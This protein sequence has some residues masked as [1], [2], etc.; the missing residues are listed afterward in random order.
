[1][2]ELFNNIKD[3]YLI[4]DYVIATSNFEHMYPE[5]ANVRPKALLKTIASYTIERKNINIKPKELLDSIIDKYNFIILDSGGYQSKTG[6]LNKTNIKKHIDFY[7]EILDLLNNDKYKNIYLFSLDFPP[8]QPHKAH[9]DSITPKESGIYT[10][11]TYKHIAK[12]GNKDRTII[13]A[14]FANSIVFNG[15]YDLFAK[16]QDD[17]RKFKYF[18]TGVLIKHKNTP[19]ITYYTAAKKFLELFDI[20]PK[21][22]HF[23]GTAS[24][25]LLKPLY[26]DNTLL[27][28][29]FD[30]ITTGHKLQLNIPVK[31][32]NNKIKLINVDI[33]SNNAVLIKH[34]CEI[35]KEYNYDCSKLDILFN[36]INP[37]RQER[38]LIRVLQELD[39][40]ISMLISIW[41]KENRLLVTNLDY[42]IT[43]EKK[44]KE[45]K[46]S[47]DELYNIIKLYFDK[48]QL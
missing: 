16:L 32:N 12:Y 10:N 48:W 9:A 18:A 8:C 30:R 31:V 24:L 22:F 1:M 41:F 35:L 26:E 33:K 44:Y 23:L 36:T 43:S 40:F 45:K 2:Q 3:K 19:V 7:Y 27:D 20:Y 37:I 46:L 17:L 13:I 15:W 28:R 11:E 39:I 6:R 47:K 29:S 5:E 4:S 21:Y 14:H 25:N 34:A 38:K 42:N